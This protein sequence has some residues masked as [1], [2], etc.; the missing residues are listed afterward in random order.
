MNQSSARG[1]RVRRSSVSGAR[2]RRRSERAQQWLLMLILLP[3]TAGA[4][5]ASQGRGKDSA[6]EP[7]P[8]Y[9]LDVQGLGGSDGKEPVLTLLVGGTIQLIL[10]PSLPTKDAVT[11]TSYWMKDSAALPWDAKVEVLSNGA[12]AVRGTV[13]NPF[14]GAIAAELGIVVT[15]A[16]GKAPSPAECRPPSCQLLRRRVQYVLPIVPAVPAK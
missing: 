4:A 14:P 5:P 13:D 2:L 3:A 1:S 16:A 12:M 8:R 15:R 7:L 11:A 10:R 9:T 6:S